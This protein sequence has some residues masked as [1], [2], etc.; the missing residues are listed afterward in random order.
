LGPRV[1]K[2]VLPPI[3]GKEEIPIVEEEEINID[4]IPF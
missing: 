2:E 1:Q 3:E 4:D